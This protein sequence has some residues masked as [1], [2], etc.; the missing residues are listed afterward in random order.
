MMCAQVAG[1]AQIVWA[2]CVFQI[3]KLGTG[4]W[5]IRTH[6]ENQTTI[7]Y[8]CV[9]YTVTLVVGPHSARMHFWTNR[10]GQLQMTGRFLPATNLRRG[11]SM[12]LRF[13]NAQGQSCTMRCK[14][15]EQ[16]AVLPLP[17]GKSAVTVECLAD[18]GV[19]SSPELVRIEKLAL[20]YTDRSTATSAAGGSH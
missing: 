20:R 3:W 16:T 10:A 12:R 17:A 9:A 5:A 8:D 1:D 6:V 15:G 2:N 4:P 13:T 7:Y 11:E 19:A 14:P 18:H